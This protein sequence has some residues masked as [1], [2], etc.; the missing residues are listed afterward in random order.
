MMAHLISCFVCLNSCTLEDIMAVLR[1]QSG[2]FLGL[3]NIEYDK[4]IHKEFSSL[5]DIQSQI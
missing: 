4:K 3:S 2:K 5:N 1:G